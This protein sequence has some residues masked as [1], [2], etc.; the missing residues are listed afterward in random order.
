MTNDAYKILRLLLLAMCVV[1]PA[2]SL[3]NSFSFFYEGAETASI[4]V[5]RLSVFVL[6][7]FLGFLLKEIYGLCFFGLLGFALGGY[8]SLDGFFYYFVFLLMIFL[9][10][11]RDDFKDLF[12]CFLVVKVF[13]VAYCSLV[14]LYI[15]LDQ[16]VRVLEVGIPFYNHI[17]H[18]SY[19]V[20]WALVCVSVL[21]SLFGK[22]YF[23][24]LFPLFFVVLI[25]FFGRG[26]IFSVVLFFLLFLF[27]DR[28]NIL[29]NV[30][31]CFFI[32]LFFVFFAMPDFFDILLSRFGFNNSSDGLKSLNTY[33]SGRLSIWSNVLDLFSTG[34]WWQQAFGFG[35][36]NYV[37]MSGFS[38]RIVHP[39]NFPLQILFDFGI[40]GVS[41]VSLFIMRQIFFFVT[42]YSHLDDSDR[43]IFFA[44]VCSLVYSLTDGVFYHYNSL[45]MAALFITY[46]YHLKQKKYDEQRKFLGDV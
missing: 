39:H 34:L 22:V 23:Q 27:M 15:S 10:Y 1:V 40:V 24:L 37:Y 35:A 46:L 4:Y 25:S 9:C 18:F 33:S 30:I 13:F 28:R 36:G 43:V 38:W 29:I 2:F 17:R 19:D 21:V 26:S 3:N 8:V 45:L 42:R 16:G 41:V 6:F 7:C 20:F 14:I 31:I 44:V 11:K 32:S 12:Y 5:N